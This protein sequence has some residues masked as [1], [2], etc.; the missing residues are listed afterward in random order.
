MDSIY[1]RYYNIQAKRQLP[2]KTIS[3]W[4]L[5]S[6]YFVAFGRLCHQLSTFPAWQWKLLYTCSSDSTSWLCSCVSHCLHGYIPVCTGKLLRFIKGS[7]L[8]FRTQTA[9]GILCVRFF[10]YLSR[11]WPGTSIKRHRGRSD[12]HYLIVL[13]QF[14]QIMPGKQ[15]V[16]A[17]HNF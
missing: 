9:L 7:N 15:N 12:W 16:P 5:G 17:L 4:T 6:C 13:S 8:L 14:Y 1:Q 2:S 10:P 11:A 3:P